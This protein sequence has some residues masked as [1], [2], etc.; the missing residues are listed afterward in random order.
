MA[1]AAVMAVAVEASVALVTAVAAAGGDGSGGGALPLLFEDAVPTVSWRRSHH[2]G[3]PLTRPLARRY[4]ERA[5][6]TAI[7]PLG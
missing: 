5:A 7:P 1:V 6:T 2:S 4:G 3:G